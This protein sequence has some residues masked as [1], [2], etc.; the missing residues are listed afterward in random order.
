MKYF[1]TLLTAST[2]SVQAD[3]YVNFLR[4]VQNDASQTTHEV[5][6]L[7]NK[8]SRAAMAGVTTSSVFELWA[9][10]TTTAEEHLLDVKTVSSYHPEAELSITSADPYTLIPRT[11]ADQ[12]FIVTYTIK[13]L[14]DDPDA[15]DAAK[16]VVLDQ[17]I[18]QEGSG[19]SSN[20]QLTLDEN[21]TKAFIYPAMS[22]ID[23]SSY[24]GSQ[25]FTLYAHPDQHFETATELATQDVI[26]FPVVS[27]S[28]T[29]V[30]NG[31][32][33]A[34]APTIGINIT[35]LY[36]R[37]DAFVRVTSASSGET[38]IVENSVTEN[39]HEDVWDFTK[40]LSG[41]AFIANED[42]DY[43]I[44][45]CSNSPFGIE[46]LQSANFTIKTTL[47]INGSLNSSE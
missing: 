45:L 44:E 46:V 34:S 20:V 21:E 38:K 23:T 3:D 37:S 15:P 47:E 36:P 6:G 11:R 40:T 28:M 19:A 17:V 33:Y 32:T 5:S 26:I 25:S 12:P 14:L 30:E 43:T 31:E 2:L 22:G 29:G 7:A 9:V 24:K 41:A 16:S 8:G 1:L 13:G 35:N 18:Q 27:G 39:P 10:N 4:Q 42:G